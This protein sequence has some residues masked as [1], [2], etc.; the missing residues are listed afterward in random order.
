MGNIDNKERE[1]LLYLDKLLQFL[2]SNEIEQEIINKKLYIMSLLPFM[3]GIIKILNPKHL[4]AYYQQLSE[5]MHGCNT[6][7]ID[8]VPIYNE[9]FGKNEHEQVLLIPDDFIGL[10]LDNLSFLKEGAYP[11]FSKTLKHTLTYLHLRLR[12]EN[13]LRETF[14]DETNRCTT[15]GDFIH[16]ALDKQKYLE[17]RSRLSSMKT[18]LNEFNHYEGNFNLFQPAIDISDESLSQERKRIEVVLEAI[19]SKASSPNTN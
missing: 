10:D 2:R 13:T 1:F 11:L 19:I 15:L 9:L 4:D 14:P 6:S 7:P 16:K 17:E 8:V 5:I 3:R 18:L 12:V